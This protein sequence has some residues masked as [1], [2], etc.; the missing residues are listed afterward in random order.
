MFPIKSQRWDS[1][2]PIKIFMQTLI[3]H[4]SMLKKKPW[5]DNTFFLFLLLLLVKS[6]K[7]KFLKR[8]FLGGDDN[9]P[10]IK[11]KSMSLR[12]GSNGYIIWVWP[13]WFGTFMPFRSVLNGV[14]PLG[15][16]TKKSLPPPRPNNRF[17]QFHLG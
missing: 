14:P 2:C 3:Y 12:P 6:F 13:K 16:S 7:H 5:V 10:K 15:Y 11:R 1:Y 9:A 4:V 17:P 8:F